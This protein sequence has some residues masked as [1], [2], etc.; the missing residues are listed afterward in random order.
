MAWSAHGSEGEAGASLGEL[1][2]AVVDFVRRRESIGMESHEAEVA[3]E[4]REPAVAVAAEPV[5]AALAE[6]AGG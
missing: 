2:S 1:H 4:V 6:V 3:V 5:E